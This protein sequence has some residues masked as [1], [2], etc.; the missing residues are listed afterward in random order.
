MK[1][2]DPQQYMLGNEGTVDLREKLL[3]AEEMLHWQEGVNKLLLAE[4]ELLRKALSYYDENSNDDWVVARS[5][6]KEADAIRGRY[7]QEK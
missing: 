2:T 7:K 1:V 5:A 3:D 4:V 6:L